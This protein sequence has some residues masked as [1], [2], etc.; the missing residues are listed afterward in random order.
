LPPLAL[1]GKDAANLTATLICQG[2]LRS[3]GG[4]PFSEEKE[5]RESRDMGEGLEGEEG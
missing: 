3:M 2:W 4:L 5:E 1:V